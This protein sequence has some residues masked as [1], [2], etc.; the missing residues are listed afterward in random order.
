MQDSK[1]NEEAREILGRYDDS[2]NAE[3]VLLAH[4]RYFEDFLRVRGPAPESVVEIP[5]E[6]LHAFAEYLDYQDTHVD[7]C[8]ISLSTVL[9]IMLRGGYDAKVLRTV[10][11]PRVRKPVENRRVESFRART[12]KPLDSSQLA[13]SRRR[14]AKRQEAAAN[15]REASNPAE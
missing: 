15:A 2:E 12:Y 11:I 8:L 7:D 5:A 3:R 10:C 6:S 4:W 1:L 13:R 14:R 9:L